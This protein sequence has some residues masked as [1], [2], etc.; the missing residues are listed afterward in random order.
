MLTITY[1]TQKLSINIPLIKSRLKTVLLRLLKAVAVVSLVVG[2]ILII[3]T[4][5]ASD[6]NRINTTQII[7]QML[8]GF[9]LCGIG[10]VL[11]FIK[12]ALQ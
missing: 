8:K 1:N 2:V 7:M 10:Y 9:T 6:L 11:N 4:A 3:S 12:I 5:G